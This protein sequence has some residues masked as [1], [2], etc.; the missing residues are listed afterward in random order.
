MP[1]LVTPRRPRP[2]REPYDR[3]HYATIAQLRAANEKIKELKQQL[4][5]AKAGAEYWK[6]E[7]DLIHEVN[8][9][10]MSVHAM[11][12]LNGFKDNGEID[13]EELLLRLRMMSLRT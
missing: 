5:A 13:Q 4:E 3:S 8:E 12:L 7:Y 10:V 11:R 9:E 6:I 2:Y 1:K